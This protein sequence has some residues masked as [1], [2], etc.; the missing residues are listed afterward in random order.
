MPG[1]RRCQVKRNQR[2]E[3]AGG[4]AGSAGVRRA[5]SGSARTSPSARSA[6]SAGAS[7]RWH[8]RSP[9]SWPPRRRSG[10]SSIAATGSSAARAGCASSRWST[11]SRSSTC[12]RPCGGCDDLTRHLPTPVLF[13]IE[14]R[15][16]AADDIPLSTG[17]R[18]DVG[19]DRRPPVPR[20]AVRGVLRRRR[21]DHGRLRRPAALGQAARPAGG[22][23]EGPVPA[24][25]RASPTPA[26]GSIRTARSPTRT[27][28]A[29]SADRPM[30]PAPWRPRRRRQRR[31]SRPPTVA[32]TC[33]RPIAA[34]IRAVVA[35]SG[36]AYVLA[37]VDPAE[38]TRT[39]CR[40]LRRRLEARRP[41]LAVAG[42][43]GEI[44]SLDVVLV[45]RPAA[46]VARLERR[47][48]LDDHP[49][50]R[51]GHPPPPRRRG[52]RRRGRAR[53]PR[54]WPGRSARAV[55]RAARPRRR[56]A[57]GRAAG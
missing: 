26:S 55:R 20:H 8:R 52:V 48:D 2:T 17:S 33:C 36:H 50:V 30:R 7:R 9:S 56:R 4:A 51:A 27:S 54:S 16:S 43:D 53:H 31:R 32:S 57:W 35:F 28:T 10:S 29:C 49:R 25:G 40:R 46:M 1:T 22:D 21:A 12:P 24:V 44:G 34:G 47:H 39:R 18:A 23:A 5:T 19:V 15:V 38:L 6:G 45:A 41:S 42:S 14:V 13:P 37:D 3:D 11:A